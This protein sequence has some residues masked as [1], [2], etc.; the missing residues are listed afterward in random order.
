MGLFTDEKLTMEV[1]NLKTEVK[2]LK[3]H[4]ESC[5]ERHAACEVRHDQH[6]LHRRRQDDAINHNTDAQR[7]LAESIDK[8]TGLLYRV[9]ERV[10][11]SQPQIDFVR[12]WRTT[13]TNNK[14]ALSGIFWL[15]AG[16]STMIGTYLV[17]KGLL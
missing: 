6:Q 13:I 12:D 10:D 9:L 8:L 11:G 17:V 4:R 14:K 1:E 15:L 2:D 7:Q 16:V 5:N 3:D